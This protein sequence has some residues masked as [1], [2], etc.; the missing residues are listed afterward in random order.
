MADP[1]QAYI[2]LEAQ[3]AERGLDVEAVKQALKRQRIKTPSWG[4]STAAQEPRRAPSRDPD[5]TPESSRRAAVK[6]GSRPARR[7]GAPLHEHGENLSLYGGNSSS[8]RRSE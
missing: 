2:L 3:L 7:L 8:I 5:A 1:S 4:T 6:I